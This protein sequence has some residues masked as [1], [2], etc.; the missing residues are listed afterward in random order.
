MKRID[1]GEQLGV[2]PPC[3]FDSP[4]TEL[5]RKA[6]AMPLTEIR[7]TT[8]TMR[9]I[10]LSLVLLLLLQFRAT[11]QPPVP[12][13]G[14]SESAA[15]ATLNKAVLDS[16]REED[17]PKALETLQTI[18]N[19][20]PTDDPFV[21]RLSAASGGLHRALAQLDTDERYDLLHKWS[22]PAADNADVRVLTS[23]VPEVAPPMEFARALGQRPQKESFAISTIGEM[24]G[25]FCSAWM[26]IVAADDSGNLRQLI[27]EL[28]GLAAKKVKNAD[29]MLALAKIRDSRSADEDLKA[30]LTAR[31]APEG[32]DRQITAIN[33][34]VLVAAALQR[35]A[36]GPACEQI[37]ERLNQFSFTQGTSPHV[38]FLRRLRAMVILKNRSPESD[39]KTVLYETPPLWIAADDQKHDG[40]S[41]GSDRAIWL[42]HEEHI[43]RLSGPGNDLLLFK[44][45]LT[46]NFELKGEVTAMDHGGAGMTYGGLAFDA[47]P[48][49]F[50]VRD[51]HRTHVERRIWPFVAPKEMRMFNRVSI[52]S[53]G[54][55]I[56]FLSNLHPGWNGSAASC[57]SSPWLGLMAFGDGRVYFRN[58]ELIGEPQIP[59]EVRIVDSADL[60]GWSATY[61]ETIP[62]AVTPFQ[63]A[64]AAQ[65][66]PEPTDW[67]VADG[68]LHGQIAAT[69]VAD[70][71]AQSHLAYMRPLLDGEMVSY[72]FFHEDG[73]TSVHPVLGR[74]AFL[75]E[76]GGVRMHWLTDNENEWT[77][78]GADNAIVEPLN[79]RGPRSLPLKSA[80]WNLLT[81]KLAEDKVSV[82]LNGEEICERPVNDITSRQF[83]FYHY[84]NTSAVQIRNVVLTGDWPEKLSAEQLQKL[85]AVGEQ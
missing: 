78:I 64:P 10:A 1:K 66:T 26:M 44:Y 47:N 28:E 80:D 58:L 41:T 36:L 56:T 18:S 9:T 51:V 5:L 85:V 52:R 63:P 14:G 53:D 24:P 35:S 83:G 42:T 79:R 82:S 45:P 20:H 75:I 4:P 84:R 49:F 55:K 34:A 31:V 11:A 70:T 81:L 72:E 59:R 71:V 21:A 40:S 13:A 17:I 29:F 48:E 6:E 19:L 60:R 33:D 77:G 23:L 2:S 73:R 3:G 15:I 7:K 30:L 32:E 65:P 43:K 25:I 16:L 54:E 74:L 69:P 37:A 67:H 62:K 22:M 27:T 61:S 68:V 38:P 39:P 57:S 46:G 50:T 12:V 8:C 76:T